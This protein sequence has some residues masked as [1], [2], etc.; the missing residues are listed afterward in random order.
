MTPVPKALMHSISKLSFF[1]GLRF[2]I[3]AQLF[4]VVFASMALSAYLN[5]SN[6]D[7]TQ[8]QLA[9]SRVLVSVSEVKRAISGALGLGLSLEELS[10]LSDILQRGLVSSQSAGVLDLSIL[11]NQGDLVASSSSEKPYWGDVLSWPIERQNKET[12][13]S[14]SSEHFAIGIPLMNSFSEQSG[15]LIVAYDGKEQLVARGKMLDELLIDLAI[16][17]AVALFS[18]VM[19]IYWL[20]N[21]FLTGLER[22][23][24]AT[25][26]KNDCLD[27]Q[28]NEL[29]VEYS[30][31]NKE[32]MAI[33]GNEALLKRQGGCDET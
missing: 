27:Q 25:A 13:R 26:Q 12:L 24:D 14:L 22:V 16:A 28:V 21:P 1:K 32:V 11:N 8:R 17:L 10:N 33:L 30:R 6:F 23:R 20:M 19:G 4:S 7:K 2:R 15:W 9:E 29:S 3:G 18:L 5:Y 31:F